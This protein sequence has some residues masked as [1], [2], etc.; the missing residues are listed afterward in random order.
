[1]VDIFVPMNSLY[2]MFLKLFK[3]NLDIFS[4]LYRFCIVSLSSHRLSIL[5]EIFSSYVSSLYPIIISS[6]GALARFGCVTSIV[7]SQLLYLAF[8]A[9]FYPLFL[10]F[11]SIYCA[12]TTHDN[13]D[14]VHFTC[15]ILSRPPIDMD[16]SS[17]DRKSVV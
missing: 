15:P 12:F 10:C 9:L 4:A 8:Q 13:H 11:R 3:C 1:M 7:F 17:A 16:L 2:P 6:T 14:W 5:Q